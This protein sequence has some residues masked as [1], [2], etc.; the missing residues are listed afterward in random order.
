MK[1]AGLLALLIAVSTAAAET[2]P[3]LDVETTLDPKT[4]VN[5]FDAVLLRDGAAIRR[6]AT[7]DWIRPQVTGYAQARAP[8][9]VAL[10]VP[11]GPDVP[12][13]P[14]RPT[15]DGLPK[16]PLPGADRA[17]LVTDDL[18][19]SMLL[20]IADDLPGL[21]LH[22]PGGL[23]NGPGPDILIA[24]ASL[25]AGRV[26][27]ACPG[28]PSPGADAMVAR[29]ANGA[30]STLAPEAFVDVGP[31]GPQLNHG[32]RALGATDFRIETLDALASLEMRPIASLDYFKVYAATLDLA[33]MGVAEGQAIE[34]LIL[35]SSGKKVQ[36]A[37]G[38]RLCWTADP[39]LV[40]G[41]PAP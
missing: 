24:E 41:L 27:G 13:T 22:F 28:V 33:D 4:G 31:A 7:S 3:L 9:V 40:V 11:A 8:I 20:N 39:I 6:V 2:G 5:R 36:T 16:T 37:G 14:G 26:S 25:A 19:N 23:V 34:T 15:F 12:I 17:H 10:G 38:P 1:G 29:L 30:E 32:T 21:T 18:A 35:S